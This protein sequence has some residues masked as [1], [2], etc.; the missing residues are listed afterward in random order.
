[1]L[2]WF[3]SAPGRLYVVATL[4]PLAAFA[5]LLVGGAV[6]ALCRP[7]RNSGGFAE[8][9]YWVCGGDKPLKTGA[10]FATTFMALAA[11]LGVIGL[12]RYLSDP[13]EGALRA[14]KWS[15]RTDW[16]RLGAP[17]SMTPA[18]WERVRATDPDRPAPP[19]ARALEVGYK[20][21]SLTAVMFAMVTVVSTLIF[22]FSLGYMKDE[23]EEVVE[24]HEVDEQTPGASP[25]HH[26]RRR[27]R[28]G[29]FFL[30]LSLFCFSMLNLVI[31]DNLFQVFVSWEL[32]GVCSFFLIGFYY[33]R[34]SA[35]TAANKA[36]IVNR[37]GDAGFLVG[38]LIAW[39]YLGTLNIEEMRHRVRSP[40]KDSHGA[41][42][43]ANQ[44]IR[45]KPSAEAARDGTPQYELPPRNEVG[46][47]S[48][49]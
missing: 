16:V 13:S 18:E 26:F 39:T 15:E 30:Y 8:T 28:F 4:L 44:F 38:I 45:V 47:G 19:L 31:A 5:V 23:A 29:R 22:I 42:E 24:D 40:E 9:L 35:S 41:Y 10:Y 48:H 17:D 46:T 33:E 43:L 27:G 7:F 20:I 49:V 11:V 12:A 2:S 32:V 3:E 37:V 36:F 6:R 25:D 34:P 1:M 14:A 21:D